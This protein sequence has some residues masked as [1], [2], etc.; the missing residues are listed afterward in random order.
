ML[1][2]K[3]RVAMSGSPPSPYN[4]RDWPGFLQT[5][6][7]AVIPPFASFNTG[8]IISRL[9]NPGAFARKWT[10]PLNA[11]DWIHPETTLVMPLSS[12]LPLN[13]PPTNSPQAPTTTRHAGVPAGPSKR[14]IRQSARIRGRAASPA[15]KA[16]TSWLWTRR[17]TG[18][19]R[20]GIAAIAVPARYKTRT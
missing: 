8:F 3:S 4:T 1:V 5:R 6:S 2:D 11:A 9:Q 17:S 16:R 19:R 13:P 12:S 18:G 10:T 7:I 14:P 20:A 15:Q